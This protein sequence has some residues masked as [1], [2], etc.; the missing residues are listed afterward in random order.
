MVAEA[1]I[2]Y[3]STTFNAART[4]SHPSLYLIPL[5]CPV[6]AVRQPK[7]LR[8]LEEC[9]T[10]DP[11]QLHPR[12]LKECAVNLA[13]SFTSLFQACRDSDTYLSTWKKPIIA[14]I[15]NK[16]GRKLATSYRPVGPTKTLVE[17]LSKY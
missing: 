5:V 1:F 13:I 10:F 16:G 14:Q 9:C 15:C 3:F 11:D 2:S 12:M 17:S 4:L 7:V 6:S 8:C